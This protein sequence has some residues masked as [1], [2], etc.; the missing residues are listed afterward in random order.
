MCI[1]RWPITKA[2]LGLT[3]AVSGSVLE[4]PLVVCPKDDRGPRRRAVSRIMRAR[5]ISNKPESQAYAAEPVLWGVGLP[6]VSSFTAR[7][8]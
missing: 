7:D 4:I 5:F 1:W 8:T 6:L 2:V 3:D